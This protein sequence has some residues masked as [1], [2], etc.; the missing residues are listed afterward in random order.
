MKHDKDGGNETLSEINTPINEK[1]P[2]SIN[3]N[4]YIRCNNNP[5]NMF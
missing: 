4:I 3:E 5:R 1:I 2:V